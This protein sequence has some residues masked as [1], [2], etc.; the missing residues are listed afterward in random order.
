MAIE[1]AMCLA[2]RFAATRRNSRPHVSTMSATALRERPHF[3][4]AAREMGRLNHLSGE[5]ARARDATLAARDPQDH[6]GSAWIFDGTDAAHSGAPASFFGPSS[7]D[8]FN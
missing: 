2:E 5:A 3:Q 1:D 7:R 6:E 8:T 4:T